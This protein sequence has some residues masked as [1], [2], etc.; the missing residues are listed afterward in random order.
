[1]RQAAL[2]LL[3]L[4]AGTGTALRRA[5]A[6]TC[7]ETLIDAS[8]SAGYRGVQLM[9]IRVLKTVAPDILHTP[10]ELPVTKA[11][12]AVWRCHDVNRRD[13]AL[14]LLASMAISP[15]ARALIRSAGVLSEMPAYLTCSRWWAPVAFILAMTADD[16][17]ARQAM[18]GSAVMSTLKSLQHIGEVDALLGALTTTT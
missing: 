10:N 9:A 15:E 1:M 16:V 11:A 6:E 4:W 13:S 14:M 8:C 5:V 17:P 12:L 18:A 3:A 2:R 7:T